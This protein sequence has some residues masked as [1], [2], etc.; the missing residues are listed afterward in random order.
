MQTTS[1][2]FLASLLVA[3]LLLSSLISQEAFAGRR[4]E[5]TRAA[6]LAARDAGKIA[7]VARPDDMPSPAQSSRCSLRLSVNPRTALY[8]ATAIA[9]TGGVAQAFPVPASHILSH[10]SAHSKRL[11]NKSPFH[12]DLYWTPQ[13]EA[14]YCLFCGPGAATTLLYLTQEPKYLNALTVCKKMCFTLFEAFSS[15]NATDMGT[16]MRDGL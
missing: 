7:Q 14:C 12:G 4:R 16:P 6:A 11:C 15:F 13:G 9:M 5:S 3:S 1:C 8:A 10:I 2:S